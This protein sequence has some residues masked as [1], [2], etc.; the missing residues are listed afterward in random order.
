MVPAAR[1]AAG[2]TGGAIPF[3]PLFGTK[4]EAHFAGVGDPRV[5]I[6][7]GILNDERDDTKPSWVLGFN[8]KIPAVDAADPT[9]ANT[10][11]DPGPA[12]DQFHRFT[13]WT[14]ISK[15]I[16]SDRAIWTRVPRYV[17]TR[18]SSPP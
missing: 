12:G 3:S 14:A 15:R 16:L 8:Y 10:E 7:W 9:A 5:G 18:S 17:S 11:D 4:G 6:A 13:F 2:R 1:L